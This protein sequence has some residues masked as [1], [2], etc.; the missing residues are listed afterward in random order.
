MGYNASEVRRVA[1]AMLLETRVLST[2]N[3]VGDV[4]Q[5]IDL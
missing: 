1:R 2:T 4:I 5:D 3:R